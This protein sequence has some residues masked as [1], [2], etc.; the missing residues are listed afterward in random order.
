MTVFKVNRGR[1]QYTKSIT[2]ITA[3]YLRIFLSCPHIINNTETIATI[4]RMSVTECFLILLILK[5]NLECTWKLQV[6]YESIYKFMLIEINN[7]ERSALNIF[8][9][10]P[11]LPHIPSLKENGKLI[12]LSA[13]RIVGVIQFL[14]LVTCYR[15]RLYKTRC[16][17]NATVLNFL[18]YAV[19]T[20]KL[21]LVYWERTWY[22]L[23]KGDGTWKNLRSSCI[24][25]TL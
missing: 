11:I 9:E 20:Q 15:R 24:F 25:C 12:E 19:T 4:W 23:F 7:F 16:P 10:P 17:P 8:S 3:L 1:I 13:S 2:Q 6:L 5:E 22:H 14:K 18:Q 21:E